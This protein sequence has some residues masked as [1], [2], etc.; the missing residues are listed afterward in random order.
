MEATSTLSPRGHR[1]PH[2]QRP[3]PG[4][5]QSRLQRH[6]RHRL[7]R[8]RHPGRTRLCHRGIDSRIGSSAAVQVVIRLAARLRHGHTDE[9]KKRITL[10]LFS[11]TFFILAVYVT[12]EGIK[13]LVD[14]EAPES[15]PVGI[16][17]LV[18][19]LVVMPVLAAM[20]KRVGTPTPRKRKSACCSAFPRSWAW[21][22]TC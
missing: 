14:G 1:T 18:L 16:G 17:I 2:R 21:G 11:V 20:K 8:S 19:S 15:S 4:P 3:P 13:S 10:N 6:R 22:C 9:R 5:V 7:R 12:Y